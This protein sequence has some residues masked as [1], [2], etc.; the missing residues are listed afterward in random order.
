MELA[1]K[2]ISQW[3]ARQKGVLFALLA[4]LLYALKSV[5]IKSAPPIKVEQIVFF[6]YLLDFLIL[7]PFFFK[8]RQ[9]LASKRLPLHMMRALFM[10]SSA[11]CSVYG[12]KHLALVDALLLEST[13]PLFIPLVLWIWH[14]QG[15][16][17][18]SSFILSLG[19]ISVF[20]LLK[21]KLNIVHIASFASLGTG[22]FSAITTV[23]IKTLA[24]TESPIAILFYFNLFA[25]IAALALSVYSWESL[26]PITP[27]FL[28]PLV[29][30]SIL[31][32]LFQCCI[33]QAYSLISP[34]VVGSFAYFSILF[35]ALFGWWIWQESLDVLQALGGILL[36]GAGILMIL[37]NRK[38]TLI[39]P[40]RSPQD[41]P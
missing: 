26:P 5:A 34:H 31:G 23:S 18:F 30:N 40:E 37:E 11:C 41:H 36:V 17:L 35:S 33:V 39:S 22:L 29:M 32:V 1:I 9:Q 13:M 27:S 38:L 7:C 6:R 19:F 14:R 2:S 28:A 3:S 8:A 10:V 24:K 21:P 16:T 20:L 25:G 15:I 12:I 4:P